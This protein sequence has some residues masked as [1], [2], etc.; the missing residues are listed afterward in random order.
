MSTI[1]T[2]P[3]IYEMKL[4]ARYVQMSYLSI[5]FVGYLKQPK[6]KIM[7]HQYV[8]VGFRNGLGIM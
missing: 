2:Y 7:L 8:G 6:E 1:H 4:V 3:Q 5:I